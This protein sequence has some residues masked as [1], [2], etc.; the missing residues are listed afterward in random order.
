MNITWV[1]MTV[2]KIL[3]KQPPPNPPSLI[4]EVVLVLQ[5]THLPSSED[6]ED[7]YA[8]TNPFHPHPTFSEH[9]DLTVETF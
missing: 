5:D 3:L 4:D 7:C 2:V 9:T 1:S 8:L 6:L